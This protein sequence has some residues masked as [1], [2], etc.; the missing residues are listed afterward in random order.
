MSSWKG[1]S[2]QPCEVSPLPSDTSVPIQSAQSHTGETTS[3]F[4]DTN[5]SD[6]EEPLH[7]TAPSQQ[8]RSNQGEL[9]DSGGDPQGQSETQS[10]YRWSIV[11]RF[12]NLARGGSE[13]TSQIKRLNATQ[14]R[15]KPRT[16][17]TEVQAVQRQE[18][19]DR[20]NAGIHQDLAQSNE[21]GK[22]GYKGATE[23]AQLS[24]KSVMPCWGK[25]PTQKLMRKLSQFRHVLSVTVEVNLRHRKDCV[26]LKNKGQFTAA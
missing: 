9:S 3:G 17:R 7:P 22:E 25:I 14:G 21:A 4:L 2:Q 23:E 6:E 20:R 10:K 16:D 13:V 11:G 24:R 26:L 8:Q 12:Q 15:L 19:A 5:V 1:T 18:R